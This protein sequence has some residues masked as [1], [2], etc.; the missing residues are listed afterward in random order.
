MD[1]VFEVTQRVANLVSKG[2]DSMDICWE[3]IQGPAEAK[4]GRWGASYLHM[5]RAGG[6]VR[7]QSGVRC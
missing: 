6:L 7:S 1:R 2:K 4:M 3:G 5:K